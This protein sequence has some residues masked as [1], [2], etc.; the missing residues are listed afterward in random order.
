MERNKR[1]AIRIN[2]AS[3]QPPARKPTWHRKV[4]MMMTNSHRCVS[5]SRMLAYGGFLF[6]FGGHVSRASTKV[7]PLDAGIWAGVNRVRG[8]GRKLGQRAVTAVPRGSG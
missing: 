7:H 4:E 1:Q 3:K 5:L 8:P 6:P 2:Y